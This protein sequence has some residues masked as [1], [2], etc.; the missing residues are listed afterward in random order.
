MRKRFVGP[1][2]GKEFEETTQKKMF[3]FKT[4]ERHFVPQVF[5]HSVNISEITGNR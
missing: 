3:L 5:D 4:T 2:P 1:E